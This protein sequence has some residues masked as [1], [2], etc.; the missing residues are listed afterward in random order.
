MPHGRATIIQ[1]ANPLVRALDT[2]ADRFESWVR[3]EADT[4]LPLFRIS[5]LD[6]PCSRIS[7]IREIPVAKNQNLRFS[8]IH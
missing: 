8:A 7:A 6:V 3:K 5:R 1:L 4:E 2:W